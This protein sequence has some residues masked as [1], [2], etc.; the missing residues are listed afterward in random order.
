MVLADLGP[1]DARAELIDQRR[2]D[3]DSSTIF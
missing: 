1:A 2:R 3:A